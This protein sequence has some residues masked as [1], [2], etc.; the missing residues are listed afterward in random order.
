MSKYKAVFIDGEWDGHRVQMNECRDTVRV[1]VLD[2]TF[3]PRNADRGATYEEHNYDLVCVLPDDT[4][5]YKY[6][7]EDRF[8]YD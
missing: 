7:K 5:V 6:F 8:R 4:L 2:N 1:A 3:N